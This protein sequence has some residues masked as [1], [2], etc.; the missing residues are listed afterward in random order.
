MRC[1]STN[2]SLYPSRLQWLTPIVS[3]ISETPTCMLRA[4]LALGA[5][6][7]IRS[8]LKQATTTMSWHPG[9]PQPAA[10]EPGSATRWSVA[11]TAGPAPP[12]TG[13]PIWPILGGKPQSELVYSKPSDP[14][15]KPG[16]GLIA[17]VPNGWIGPDISD[18]NSRRWF[19]RTNKGNSLRMDG[20]N[21][22]H[23]LPSQQVDH[24]VI[25]CNGRLL[26]HAGIPSV[27][28]KPRTDPD[29]HIPATDW[30]TWGNWNAK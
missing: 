11:A 12:Y 9:R 17:R 21:P 7:S 19:D 15:W 30:L 24:I 10:R 22:S 2:L 29:V 5:C 18:K 6:R 14:N 27:H 3:R 8:R 20:G 25:Q 16:P 26:T 1:G 4:E 28:P 13:W 23:T